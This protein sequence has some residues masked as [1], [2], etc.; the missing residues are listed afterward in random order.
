MKKLLVALPMLAMLVACGG[1]NGGKKGSLPSGA[2]EKDLIFCDEATRTEIAENAEKLVNNVLN[3]KS[4]SLSGAVVAEANINGSVEAPVSS[5]DTTNGK[6]SAGLKAKGDATLEGAVSFKTGKLLGYINANA[7]GSLSANYEI[8]DN[9]WATVPEE[10]EAMGVKQKNSLSLSASNVGADVYL[11]DGNLYADV[12]KE[13]NKKLV[14]DVFNL[15]V[16]DFSAIEKAAGMKE[17]QLKQMILGYLGKYYVP[18]FDDSQLDID[19]YIAMAKQNLPEGSIKTM[20]KSGLDMI[21]S[22]DA[23]TKQYAEMAKK[24][25]ELLGVKTYVYSSGDYTYG[26][27]MN[28]DGMEQLEKVYKEV[29]TMAGES[30]GQ[31]PSSLD[32]VLKQ[33]G[34]SISTVKYS[35]NLAVGV[36]G[37]IFFGQ[38]FALKGSVNYTKSVP[39]IKGDVDLSG[40]WEYKLAAGQEDI[41]NKIPANL[42]GYTPLAF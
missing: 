18:L 25:L 41:S 26:V 14:N 20:V 12:S 29:K 36:K 24:Y 35:V 13:G 1:G 21:N 10:V 19:S 37:N 5:K 4:L 30:A 11:K 23:Q 15:S 31:L 22:D 9:L 27:T 34:V 16:V 40:S 42:N 32:A 17:G 3:A 39:A 8:S 28:I 7:N 2:K 6:V 33:Y 38:Q